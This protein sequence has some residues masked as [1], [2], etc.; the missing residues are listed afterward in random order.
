MK[1]IETKNLRFGYTKKTGTLKNVN[2]DIN[3]GEFVCVLGHNGSGKSTLAKIL[4]GLLLEYS[5]EVYI[6]GE[7][8]TEEN[9]DK[10]RQNIGIVFQNPDN[11]FVGVTVRDD[12]AFGLEN[13]CYKK[14][15]MDNVIDEYS[16]IVGME[17]FLDSNPENLSGGQK[18]RVAI[19]R[20]LCMNPDIMLFDEPTSALDP[21]LVGE[22]L[23]IMKKLAE[24]GMT[25]IV[26]THEMKFAKEVSTKVVFMNEGVILES[27]TPDEIFNNPKEAR[28]K[29]FLKRV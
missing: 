25:M 9:V 23:D 17:K 12:I 3:E 14:E 29:E 26:V 1:A 24:E 28:T 11:Q 16:K 22:V 8:L 19:A 2:I 21:E 7:L 5:G 6:M 15:D 18:Q 13:R 4:V 20:G 27:G 10:L